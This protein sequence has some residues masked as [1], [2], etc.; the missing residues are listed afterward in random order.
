[1][2]FLTD[3]MKKGYS[4][5]EILAVLVESEQ[6]RKSR[7]VL[8]KVTENVEACRLHQRKDLLTLKKLATWRRMNGFD[9]VAGGEDNWFHGP[10]LLPLTPE[11]FAA[12]LWCE[13]NVLK[14]A[15]SMPARTRPWQKTIQFVDGLKENLPDEELAVIKRYVE[16]RSREAAQMTVTPV[17]TIQYCSPSPQTPEPSPDVC[18][19]LEN[20]GGRMNPKRGELEP[21]SAGTGLETPGQTKEVHVVRMRAY[22]DSSLAVGQGLFEMAKHQDEYEIQDILN[23]GED[24]LKAG[25]YKVQVAWVGLDD[26]DPTWEPVKVMFRDVTKFLV[27][28]LKQMRLHKRVRNALR[29]RYGMKV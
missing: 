6:D 4:E 17:D 20:N 19:N 12:D 15:I 11:E 28:K 18:I 24:P 10:R 13:V 25:D 1:M 8:A 22:A 14:D 16:R 5:E 26:E 3:V 29:Q 23:I 27:R 7:W 21:P 2:T 9:R